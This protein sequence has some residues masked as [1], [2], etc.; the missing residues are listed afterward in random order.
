MAYDLGAFG[1]W[2]GYMDR[3]LIVSNELTL[4]QAAE[5]VE[6]IIRPLSED[7]QAQVL[8]WVIESQGLGVVN[9][10]GKP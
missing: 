6:K 8:A 5:A 1:L 4:C 7:E 3:S 9:W 10:E 2:C